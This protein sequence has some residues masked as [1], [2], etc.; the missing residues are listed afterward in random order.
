M[1][2]LIISQHL[3]PR[4]TPRAHRTTELI[5]EFCRRGH[6]VT[7]YAVLGKFDY[8]TFE[9][10]TGCVVKPIP[11][12]WMIYPYNSDGDNRRT[13]LDKV[14][15]KLF[16]TLEFPNIEFKYRIPQILEREKGYDLILSIADPHPIHWGVARFF[17]KYPNHRK[18]VKW[19]ADCGDP[20]IFNSSKK[21]LISFEA[22]EH[23]FCTICDYITVPVFEAINGYFPN[24]KDKIRVIPQGFDFELKE[25]EE[26]F[27]E[28]SVPTFAYAGMFYDGIRNPQLFFNFLAKRTSPFK[29]VVYTPYPEL[30]AKYKLILGDRL[31]VRES[32]DRELLLEELKKMDFLVNIENV[33][34][35]TQIPSK[36]I[37]YAIVGRPILNINP[38]SI[39]EELIIQ[40]LNRE[41][42]NRL[43]IRDIEQ[44]HIKNIV[45]KFIAL[46]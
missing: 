26:D 10:E 21:K 37:D 38:L 44:Y 14:L 36:L 4:R 25:E 9:S 46:V 35:P 6:Q 19:I 40:F 16:G 33:N 43:V 23:M 15:G 42:S 11:I 17:K 20:Y 31:E 7:V 32:I 24:Y 3:F 13:L 27:K 28:N 29:L 12:H 2:I 39:D 41:Y 45:D 22:D 8:S 1:K 5:K 34:S 18:N 30:V